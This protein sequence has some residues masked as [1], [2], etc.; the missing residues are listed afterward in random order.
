MLI[1]L[2]IVLAMG[3]SHAQQPAAATGQPESNLRRKKIL[4]HAGFTV[5]D[6]ASLVPGSFTVPGIPERWYTVDWL[7]GAIYWKQPPPVDSVDVR[8]RVL[9]SR[10]NASRHHLDFDSLLNSYISQA[11]IRGGLEAVNTADFF[12]FGNITYN[13]SFGRGISFGN[14]QN[15]VV[16]SN[17]NL[18]IAGYLAD[19]I[20]IV[21]AITDNNIPIQPDGTTQQLN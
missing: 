14:A 8:Y 6:T 17:L 15:A 12:N 9:G 11:Y 7:N 18:Q 1:L 5:I 4:V 19:S 2:L 10:L 3:V 21:A 16:S 13:G 20:E